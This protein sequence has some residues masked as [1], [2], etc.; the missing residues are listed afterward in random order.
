MSLTPAEIA[1]WAAVLAAARRDR[2]RVGC[3]PI[4]SEID[5]TI[6]DA[7]AIQRAGTALRLERGEKLVVWKLGCTSRAMRAQ[8]GIDQPS[9]GLLTDA[10]LVAH[11]GAAGL[12]LIQP[13]VEP[14]IGRSA[15]V[16]LRWLEALRRRAGATRQSGR[17]TPW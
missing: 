17:R 2:D 5:L 16:V 14:E 12:A 10:M 4:S 6:D 15:L 1:E 8:M 9:F 13:R 11:D 3:D 7:Y